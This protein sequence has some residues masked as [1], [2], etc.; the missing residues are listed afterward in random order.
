VKATVDWS[1]EGGDCHS[2]FYRDGRK[3][4]T[5]DDLNLPRG[6]CKAIWPNDNDL[7]GDGPIY[8]HPRG[9]LCH[10]EPVEPQG[11]PARYNITIDIGYLLRRYAAANVAEI[12]NRDKETNQ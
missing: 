9:T 11:F 10:I 4:A 3:I 1:M 7:C 12:T 5:I 6:A 2:A 8:L